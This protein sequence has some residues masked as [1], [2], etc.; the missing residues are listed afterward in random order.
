[1]KVVVVLGE[2][3]GGEPLAD[4]N[5]KTVLEAAKTPHLDQLAVR[6]LFRLFRVAKRHPKRPREYVHR[7]I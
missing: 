7:A 6:G 1:M 5:G 2:G 4:L 3:L